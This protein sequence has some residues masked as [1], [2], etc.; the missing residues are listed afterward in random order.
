MFAYFDDKINVLYSD[1]GTGTVGDEVKIWEY[2]DYDLV[3]II[4]VLGLGRSG[5]IYKYKVEVI[6]T[7][8]NR[9]SK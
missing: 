8:P 6:R 4:E 3:K 5:K 7:N 1:D 9:P 2:G